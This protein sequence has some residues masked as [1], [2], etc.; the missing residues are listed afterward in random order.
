LRETIIQANPLFRAIEL[1]P[2]RLWNNLLWL[3]THNRCG[4]AQDMP[5]TDDNGEMHSPPEWNPSERPTIMSEWQ[6]A[7]GNNTI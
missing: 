6:V 4:I 1:E 5:D 7:S 3:D 2:R